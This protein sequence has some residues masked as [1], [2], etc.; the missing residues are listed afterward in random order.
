LILLG[1]LSHPH[2]KIELV[3]GDL[4][5]EIKRVAAIDV[6]SLDDESLTH[7]VTDLARC[8]AQLDAAEAR[9]LVAYDNRKVWAARG[10]KSAAAD[11]AHRTGQSK[12]ECKMRLGSGRAMG[13]LP[14]AA[15]AWLAGDVTAEHVRALS[16]ACTPRTAALMARDEAVLV[17]KAKELGFGDWATVLAH[18]SMRADPDGASDSDLERRNRR[19]LS[20]SQVPNGW[21]I[22]GLLDAVGGETVAEEL[23]RI[24]QHLFDADWAE[25]KERLGREPLLG[26]LGRTSAQRRADALVEMAARSGGSKARAKPSFSVVMGAG[27]FAMLCELEASGTPITP[28]AL[29]GWADEA[30]VEAVLF[31]QGER[32]VKVSRKRLFTGACRR[33]I[34][35]RGDRQCFHPTCDESALHCQ[36]DH[37]DPHS[38]GGLTAH[39]NGRPGCG[40]HNR[41]DYRQR[42]RRPPPDDDPA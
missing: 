8:R 5:L 2:G 27:A 42:R 3:F 30:T 31:E 9:L 14:L 20:L 22:S 33:V 26:E 23:R 15:D 40:H 6:D 16:R 11:L 1:F 32:Q 41:W 24:E 35:L 12:L 17:E 37:I 4:G 38:E 18:W 13:K 7:A 19:H 28:S 29:R 39:W 25:A 21:A 10:A 34:E 36:A